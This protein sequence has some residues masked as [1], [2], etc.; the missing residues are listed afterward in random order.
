MG[1]HHTT[2]IYDIIL[3]EDG[4]KISV[5]IVMEYVENTLIELLDYSDNMNL[6]EEHVIKLLYSLLCSL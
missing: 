3:F 4:K 5:F 1:Q 2:K 6:T